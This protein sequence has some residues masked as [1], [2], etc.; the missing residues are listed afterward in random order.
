MTDEAGGITGCSTSGGSDAETIE[1]FSRT[2]WRAWAG[3]VPQ[4][5]SAH[6]IDSPTALEDRTRRM[7]VAPFS[8]ASMGKVIWLSTSEGA[9]P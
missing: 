4:S 6:T 2:I 9:I 3:S 8:E 1:S 5:N 7:P